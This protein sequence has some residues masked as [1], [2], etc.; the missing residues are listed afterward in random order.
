[1]AFVRSVGIAA[2][3]EVVS[4]RLPRKMFGWLPEATN[5]YNTMQYSGLTFLKPPSVP[6]WMMSQGLA[7]PTC[8]STTSFLP[9]IRLL[10][11]VAALVKKALDPR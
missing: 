11:L 6:I 2:V 4:L 7:I 3:V 10:F 5:T 9:D 8:C 1:M